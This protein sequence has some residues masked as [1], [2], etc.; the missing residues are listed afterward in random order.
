MDEHFDF[1]NEARVIFS[2]L[3]IHIALQQLRISPESDVE[4]FL[5]TFLPP[6]DDILEILLCERARLK[7][8]KNE[9]TKSGRKLCN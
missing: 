5:D 9:A 8:K 2:E 7:K 6:R 4:E 3:V 1:L